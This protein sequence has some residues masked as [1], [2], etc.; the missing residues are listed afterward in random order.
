ML[1]NYLQI[2]WYLLQESAP[3]L[4]L[5]LGVAGL[6]R[7]FLPP[8]FLSRHLGKRS[9]G[10]TLKAAL[11]GIPLPLCS[12]GVLPTAVS[13]YRQGASLPATFA[14]LVATPQT[15]VDAILLAYGLLGTL[16][17]LA[18][19]VSALLAAV[20]TSWALLLLFRGRSGQ[21]TLAAS[22]SLCP[23][24]EEHTHSFGERVRFAWHYATGEL[25]A[26]LARPL[27]VGFLAAALVTLLLPPD[28]A[29]ILARHGL[30]YPAMLFIGLPVY[31]CATAS[32]PLGYA[33][34]LKGFSPGSVLVFLMAGP[35]TN[36][37]SLVVLSR[38]FGRKVTLIYLFSLAL[39][40]IFCG[41]ILDLL[42]ERWPLETLTP[43]E[44]TPGFLH[45]LAA[46]ALLGLFGKHLIWQRFF[47]RETGEEGC[48]C[49][50]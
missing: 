18:Y 14:F 23:N 40:A 25:F 30:T 32:I 34:L 2:L 15:S 4:L 5:G 49:C 41:V 27:L 7:A 50:H 6:L 19:P 28:L 9:L 36:L 31:V 35:G 21:E 29:E 38:V 24:T 1:T 33:L 17:A 26:E 22:C 3:Y 13:L 20:L 16:F 42:V 46:L 44:R 37:T 10:S 11:F 12:C 39:S 8:D 45:F 48:S 47:S 43:E